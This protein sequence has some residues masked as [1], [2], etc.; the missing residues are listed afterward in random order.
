MAETM[1]RDVDAVRGRSLGSP[2]WWRFPS[3][4]IV[5]RQSTESF[6]SKAIWLI[7][8]LQYWVFTQFPG[9][10]ADAYVAAAMLALI[11]MGALFAIGCLFS[12]AYLGFRGRYAIGVRMWSIALIVTWAVSYAVLA[13]SYLVGDSKYGDVLHGAFCRALPI[14]CNGPHP[15]FGWVTGAE[16]LIYTGTAV[17]VLVLASMIHRRIAEAPVVKAPIGDPYAVIVIAT[18]AGLMVLVNGA[19]TLPHVPTRIC[20]PME[21]C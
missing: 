9:G 1:V 15:D 2:S 13:V 4:W 3:R 7:L 16:Y 6:F 18:I 21:T 19:T 5:S 10:I 17:L 14:D 11:S 8:P 12:L 20:I